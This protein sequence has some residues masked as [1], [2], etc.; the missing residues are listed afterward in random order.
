MPRGRHAVLARCSRDLKVHPSKGPAVR[1][2]SGL[3][4][5]RD[6]LSRKNNSSGDGSKQ[7]QSSLTCLPDYTVS[8]KTRSLW[9]EE[10]V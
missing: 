6:L 9:A 8:I 3:I 1:Q 4:L 10:T 7:I 2:S 5:T